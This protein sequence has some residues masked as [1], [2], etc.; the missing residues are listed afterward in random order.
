MEEKYVFGIDL[1]TTYSCISYLDEN[2][3]HVTCRSVEG[4]E[5]VPS[6]VR[7]QEGTEPVVGESAKNNAIMFPEDTIMFVKTHIGRDNFVNYG[8]DYSKEISPVSV[9]AKILEKLA[10]DASIYTN[11]VVKRVV[12]TVPAYFGQAEKEATRNA[13]LEAGLDVISI[14]EEPTASAIY[15]GLNSSKEPET[16]MVFDLGGG[17][18]DITAMKIEDKNFRVLTTDGN[19][20]LGGKNWDAKLIELVKEK[21]SEETGYD[22]DYDIDIEQELAINCEKAK[23]ALTGSEVANV[24]LRI[25]RQHAA[26]ITVT[27]QE[28][29]E[30][31]KTLLYTAID[32]TK[33][34][35]D[36][37]EEKPTKI[38]LVGGSSYMPQVK[39]AIEENFPDLQI[40]INEPN[41]SVSKGASIYAYT[42]LVEEVE[43]KPVTT[44]VPG[45]I[46]APVPGPIDPERKRVLEGYGDG[47][48][49]IGEINVQSVTTKSLG[50]RMLL[51]NQPKINNIIFKDSLLPITNSEVYGT[52]GDNATNLPIKI[53]QSTYM[54]EFYE[55]DE[56]LY[57]GETTLSIPP[58]LP[59]GSPIEV[60][61]GVEKDGLVVVRAV[62][63]T[64]NLDVKAE[65]NCEIAT[66]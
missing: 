61:I 51:N 10:N 62:D 32:L 36:R 14:V 18:F 53:Y 65:F 1:G 52:N 34:V 42:C 56:D 38:L 25:D 45:P 11:S 44:P 13:G 12:I 8:Q 15:Y 46:P 26:N 9:S 48:K 19:H 66:K 31:T 59:A 54:D 43:N 22:E 2:G 28:F 57:L 50:V 4:Q 30:S 64:R 37:L 27:R 16:I 17:T 29:E 20:D 33:S 63:K 3:Q 40:F 23:F 5:T 47:I 21:F 55:I 39:A 6:V 49:T 24:S 60:T 35:Y 41:T 58:G 7:M